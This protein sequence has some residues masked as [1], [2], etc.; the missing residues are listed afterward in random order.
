MSGNPI[1]ENDWTRDLTQSLLSRD[2]NSSVMDAE[3]TL[4]KL[5]AVF[6]ESR[7]LA[8]QSADEQ[9]ELGLDGRHDR[10]VHGVAGQAQ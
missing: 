1:T 4:T 8:T 5:A 6:L 9:A 10:I 7:F 2:T 3:S